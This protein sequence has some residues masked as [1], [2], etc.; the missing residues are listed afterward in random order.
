MNF[1][2]FSLRI[3]ADDDLLLIECV[4]LACN[5]RIEWKDAQGRTLKELQALEAMT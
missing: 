2:L 3:I 5:G 4:N 1:K